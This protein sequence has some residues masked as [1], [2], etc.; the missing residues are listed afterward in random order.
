MDHRTFIDFLHTVERLKCNTRHSWTSSGR[1]E[2]VAEH[3]W[4]LAVMALLCADEY[5]DLDHAKLVKMCLIHDWGEAL[6]GDIPSFYKTEADEVR[7]A[8]AIEQLLSPLPDAM[9]E[10]FSALFAEMEARETP[11]A[12]LFKALDNMEAIFSHNEA[13]ISTWIEKEYTE[14]LIYGVEAAAW[15]PFTADVR[16]LLRQDTLEKIKREGKRE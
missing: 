4:R 1:R 10:E 16:E 7:E 12:K 8:K 13:D 3:S 9:R 6:T 14:S 15:H 5:P 2:S 11:E